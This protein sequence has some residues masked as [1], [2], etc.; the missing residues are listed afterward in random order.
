MVVDTGRDYPH[1]PGIGVHDHGKL[2]RDLRDDRADRRAA[3]GPP[4][5]PGADDRD[6]G[7]VLGARRAGLPGLRQGLRR[8]RRHHLG[9]GCGAAAA[10]AEGDRHASCTCSTRRR[11]A[12]SSSCAAAKDAGQDVSAEINPWAVFLGNDWANIERLGLVRPVLLRARDRTPSPSGR[13]SGTARSTSSRPTTPRTRARRRSPAGPMAGRPTPGTP[14]TQ[15]YLSLLLD[16]HADGRIDLERIA[17]ATA[18]DPGPDI[19][20]R[21]QGPARGR[22]RCGHRDRRHRRRIRDHRRP[23]PEQDAAGRRTPAAAFAV[24]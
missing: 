1:M 8:P 9:H 24:P 17:D 5:R 15:F 7:A 3:H 23:R 22:G 6:R 2:L 21:Q 10:A 16:A 20:P 19:R 4:A 12:S 13:R 14:S 11:G 18:T